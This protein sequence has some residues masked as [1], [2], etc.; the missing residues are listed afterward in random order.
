GRDGAPVRGIRARPDAGRPRDRPNH[1]PA[2]GNLHR[3]RPSLERGIGADAGD[4][5]G[6]LKRLHASPGSAAGRDHPHRVTWRGHPGGKPASLPDLHLYHAGP[7][8]T[9]YGVVERTMAQSMTLVILQTVVLLAVSPFIVGL[10]RKV[11]ATLQCRRGASMAQPYYDLLK[12][13]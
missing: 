13:F 5:G 11:K 8:V 2:D 7:P 1:R 3:R 4:G 12:L 9:H 6:V 10:I